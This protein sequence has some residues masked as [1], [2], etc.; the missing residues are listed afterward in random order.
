[1]KALLFCLALCCP[2]ALAWEPEADWLDCVQAYHVG[3]SFTSQGE[4]EHFLRQHYLLEVA[5]GEPHVLTRLRSCTA[6]GFEAALE[7]RQLTA[8]ELHEAFDDFADAFPDHQMGFV[9]VYRSH[10]EN[11]QRWRSSGGRADG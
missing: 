2:F 8:S 10:G 9:Y 7:L 11:R 5:G 1:M 4:Y 6:L 3:Q